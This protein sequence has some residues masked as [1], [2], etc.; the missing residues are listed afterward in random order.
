MTIGKASDSEIRKELE[1][2]LASESFA[3]AERPSRFLRH[4]VERALDGQAAS[5]KESLIGVEVFGREPDW[6][7]RIDPIVRQ[8]AAR[9]RKRLA[10]YYAGQPDRAVEISVPLGAYV[11]EFRPRSEQ[12]NESEPVRRRISTAKLLAAL[13]GL[14]AV[15]AAVWGAV[16]L[17]RPTSEISIAVLPFTNLSSNPANE[18]FADGLT[19]EITEELTRLK[20]MRVIARTSAFQFKGTKSDVRDVA[21]RLNVSHVLE[22]SVERSD[23]RIRISA[24][25]E[26]AS[27]GSHLWSAS[28]D[29]DAKDLFSVQTDVASAIAGSL[30]LGADRTLAPRHIP[31]PEVHD[32]FMR[33]RFELLSISPEMVAKAE[34]DLDQVVREDPRYASAWFL[35]GVAKYNTS[36]VGM[37]QRTAE[38]TQQVKALYQKAL[39]L[40]PNLGGAHANL[41]FIAM[42]DWQW[43]EARRQL[44]AALQNGPNSPAEIAYALLEAFRGRLAEAARRIDQAR[45]LDPASQAVLINGAQICLWAG[46][47]QESADFSLQ[48]L[49]LHPDNTAAQLLLNESYISQKKTSLALANMQKLE[50]RLPAI[51]LIEA[52]ALGYSGRRPEGKKLL[53]ELEAKNASDPRFFREWFAAAHAV[54]GENT[55]ALDWLERSADAREF[56]VLSVKVAPEFQPL[57]PLPEFQA[58]VKRIGLD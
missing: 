5:L 48:I 32:L 12:P 41:A 14:I 27:D 4:A 38:E 17:L 22:G 21:R 7:P 52:V 18:Y 39:S 43:A 49:E 54:L 9:L 13:A 6:N 42:T 33:A 53:R 3:N 44:D 24:H 8:G 55:Q 19:D 29:R 25:L 58:L 16:S 34:Q 11:P 1:R 36:A 46:R 31:A 56:Q 37:R 23:D 20:P 2:I 15:T 47:Y 57:R 28:Y 40:D 10:Q 45:S 30:H 50:P 26:R 51:G 35:L